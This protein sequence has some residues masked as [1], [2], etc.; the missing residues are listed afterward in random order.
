MEWHALLSNRRLGHLGAG[1]DA[2]R[3]EF[4]RDF[5]RIVYSSAFRRL[6]DKTQVYALAGN[7]YVRTRLT[8]SIEVSCVGRS[9]GGLV[10]AFLKKQDEVCLDP[11]DVGDI[12]AAACL[13]HDIGN[14][15][16]GH[17]GEAAIQSWFMGPGQSTMT[18]L[19]QAERADFLHFEGNAQGFRVLSRLQ[20]AVNQG[21]MQLTCAV[22]GAFAK[23]PRDAMAQR[24]RL[25]GVSEKKHGYFRA[26]AQLFAEVAAALG[27]RALQGGAWCRHPLAFL[28][29][30]A[31]DICYCIVDIEDGHR[32]GLL[33]FDEARELLEP[34]AF[35]S[36]SS[37]RLNS[38]RLMIDNASRVSYL[39]AKAIGTLVLAVAEVFE[40][41]HNAIIDGRLDEELLGRTAHAA[42][43][44]RIRDISRRKI[45][46]AA[47]DA[48]KSLVDEVLGTILDAIVAQA[49]GAVDVNDALPLPQQF[50]NGGSIYER[51]LSATDFVSG[52]TDSYAMS[53]HRRLLGVRSTSA[54][55]A[56]P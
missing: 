20:Y 32:V 23:Y 27:L 28:M 34:I 55:A 21:G 46:A 26:D 52:M 56:A 50:R 6:Q 12:V 19:T 31:D 54:S 24:S 39:R 22:L 29:E 49:L 43:L 1:A 4:Q 48:P 53:A 13:A 40:Q 11:R 17:A 37:E 14:P 9:L 30:A 33:S 2:S 10:G 42:Q 51:L 15:P 35:A 41:N 44:R 18:M 8:H 3:S 16:F 25:L 45:Y 38:Y 47:L 5:D 7:D 36:A